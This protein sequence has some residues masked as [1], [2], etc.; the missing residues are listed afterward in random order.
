VRAA[1][2]SPAPSGGKKNAAL[3]VDAAPVTSVGNLDEA[4]PTHPKLRRGTLPNGLRY[5]VL[6][7]PVPPRRFEAHLE[8][9][10]GSVDEQEH[11]QG[12][13]HLVEHVVF[14]GSRKR[15]LLLG[16]G[17]RSNAYTDFHHTVFHVHSPVE[18]TRGQ[19]MTKLALDALNEIAFAPAFLAQR[20][21]KERKAV[22]SELQMMNTIEYRVDCQLLER[23]HLENALGHRFPIGKQEQI[24]TWA[25][26]TVR[27]YHARNYFPSNATLY[28]VGDVDPTE[29]ERKIFDALSG[30]SAQLE[31]P[32]VAYP[33]K[34][35][36]SAPPVQ[37]E[38]SWVSHLFPGEGQV[39]RVESP[40]P[41][42]FQHAMLET[43]QL[44]LFAKAPPVS[45]CTYRRLRY[46]IITRLVM[47]MIQFRISALYKAYTSSPPPF[48][49]IEFDHSD[50]GREG[51]TVTTLNVIADASRWRD[52]V[53][54]TVK[55]VR[56]L[57]RNGATK[58]ELQRFVGMMQADSEQLAL[59]M[60]LVPS[61]DNLDFIMESDAL[62][63]CVMDQAQGHEAMM[64]ASE[65]ITLQEV[66]A[67]AREMLSFVAQYGEEDAALPAAVVACVPVTMACAEDGA[68]V[69]F[70]ITTADIVAALTEREGDADEEQ[71]VE[72]EVPD[73]L[74]TTPQ[75]L[76]LQQARKPMWVPMQLLANANND[77][78][79]LIGAAP[80]CKADPS[81]TAVET[82]D[83]ATGVVQRRLQNGVAVNWKHTRN[84]PQS[85]MLR[86]VVNGGRASEDASA[87]G[88][89]A[90]G[91][92]TMSETGTFYEFTREQVEL[93][94]VSNLINCFVEA[95]EEFIC[96]DFHF[97]LR[98]GG[99]E[100]L[101]QLVHLILTASNMD[102]S[103]FERAR[104][105]Y[106][107][108]H[109]SNEKGLEKAA[110][111]RLMRAMT[112]GDQ[113]FMDPT[114]E[115]LQSLTLE[116][117]RL[118]IM[119]QLRT[120]QMEVSVVGDF[121]EQEL[122]EALVQYIGTLPT[123]TLAESGVL[124][125]DRM[126][127]QLTTDGAAGPESLEVGRAGE[128]IELHLDDSDQRACAYLAGAGPNRW[129]VGGP[130]APHK[131]RDPNWAVPASALFSSSLGAGRGAEAADTAGASGDGGS[132][133]SDALASVDTGDSRADTAAGGGG[134]GAGST[135]LRS[136]HPLYLSVSLALL[137][138]VINSRLF[139]TVRDMLGLTYDV[140]FQLSNFDRLEGGWYL[141]SVTSTPGK[142]HQAAAASLR[143]LRGFRMQKVSQQ[144]LDRARRTLLMRH[145]SDLKDN[146]YWVGLLT[147]LQVSDHRDLSLSTR[148]D[149]AVGDQGCLAGVVQN[150]TVDSKSIAC[151]RDLQWMFEHATVDDLAYAYK[152]FA[153]AE[154][155]VFSIVAT[156]GEK[157]DVARN[158]NELI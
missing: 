24:E 80:S 19:D 99:L 89:V 155:E 47:S 134:A 145:E 132:T 139:T 118:A 75:L 31:M 22:L 92:R 27:A 111:H 129:G 13:A 107:S 20:V 60:D 85:A 74:M 40:A 14:L 143:V 135:T 44:T 114:A 71:L 18:G 9:H 16:S 23:L 15:E 106:L 65:G 112:G 6:P 104:Q 68:E 121:E 82:R 108:L 3:A 73:V 152:H 17:S 109:R 2:S 10:A 46:T 84:E 29:V 21:E 41:F 35:R 93:Y 115:H 28:V 83:P 42:V 51:C 141:L 56:R 48:I 96:M 37:H 32:G 120:D 117:S 103:G 149:R 57:W 98:A 61:N 154:G 12:I 142:V 11:E 97:S 122:T 151:V 45:V 7:N 125:D 38:W 144:E 90:V 67:V 153:V 130:A 50:S 76:A 54:V 52:A 128:Q 72:V 100:R 8:I 62:G 131:R 78:A 101:L 137:V 150:D 79:A 30:A 136:A 59:Q 148:V 138:E 87:V 53:R 64:R 94:C 140:S 36:P 43:F 77:V 91:T 110:S 157:E 158:P 63:H 147:H 116:Q 123:L 33:L 5:V 146:L 86:V 69:P 34:A 126:W 25:R 95:D 1:A 113:R 81:S 133:R 88:A 4:L 39:A 66:N 105:H 55:E 156:S 102:R 58:A 119:Q 70:A 127:Q 49:A 26:D 124:G